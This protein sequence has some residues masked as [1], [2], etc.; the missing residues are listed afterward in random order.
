[1]NTVL[2]CLLFIYFSFSLMIAQRKLIAG[3]LCNFTSTLPD[4]LNAVIVCV[5]N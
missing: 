2:F 4:L 5:A 1:M 3:Q